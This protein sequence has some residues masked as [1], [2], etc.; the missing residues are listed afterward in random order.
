M[1]W[2]TIYGDVNILRVHELRSA[3]TLRYETRLWQK[4]YMVRGWKS[5]WPRKKVFIKL[6]L[7]RV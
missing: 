7:T 4:K 3:N 5:R 6:I 2:P 1:L